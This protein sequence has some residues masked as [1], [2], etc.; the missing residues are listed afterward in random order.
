MIMIMEVQHVIINMFR[1][2]T[3]KLLQNISLNL[4]L[5]HRKE[6][7]MTQEEKSILLKDLCERLPY[8]ITI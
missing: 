6:N 2:M 4:G 8:G 1:L 5:K 3:T 7:N